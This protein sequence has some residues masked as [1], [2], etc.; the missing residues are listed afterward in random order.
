MREQTLRTAAATWA[1]TILLGS[2]SSAAADRQLLIVLDGL[3]PDYVT[4]ETMPNLNALAQGGVVFERHHAIYPTVTRVNAASIAA[5]SHPGTH[6]LLGNTVYLPGVKEEPFTTSDRANLLS[7]AEATG[8][9]LDV[10][11]LGDALEAAGKRLFVASSGSSG[12]SFLL[13]PRT[14]RGTI[15]SAA[16]GGDHLQLPVHSNT[17]ERAPTNLNHQYAAIC[18]RNRPFGKLQSPRQHGVIIHRI[19]PCANSAP[20]T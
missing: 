20:L 9:I 13:H 4:V 14:D 2:V 15:G 8:G 18:H 16:R 6:G 19:E 7:I 3:R 1:C 12:S 10:Q 17:G 11:T 5:G